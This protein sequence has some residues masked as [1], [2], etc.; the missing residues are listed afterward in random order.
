[1]LCLCIAMAG[2]SPASP[3]RGFSSPVQADPAV[4]LVEEIT[5][6]MVP[7]PEGRFLMGSDAG[8]GED[9]QPVH[10]VSIRAF[11]LAKHELTAAQFTVFQRETGR[12]AE[13]PVATPDDHPAINISWNDAM[14]FIAWLNQRGRLRFRLPSEAEWEYAARAGTTTK[15]WWGDDP[16]PGRVNGTGLSGVDVWSE[17][18]PVGSLLPNGFGLYHILG[19]VWEWTADCYSG[20]YAGAPGDGSARPGNEACGR[21]LRGGSWSD[22][23]TW[24]RT[25]TRNWFDADERFDYVGLRLAADVGTGTGDRQ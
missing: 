12:A 6:G 19:N 16:V 5:Q 17:T 1:M 21:V 22:S 3:G 24:L 18:A 4:L 11:L 8:I 14:A 15:Y 9:E 10:P 23:P 13:A 20:D 2:C 25:S 7:I